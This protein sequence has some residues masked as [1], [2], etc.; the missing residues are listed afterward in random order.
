ML[1]HVRD[2]T[3][4]MWGKPRLS[5]VGCTFRSL[6]C[7]AQHSRLPGV[8]DNVAI[9]LRPAFFCWVWLL[10]DW[11]NIRS[12][13]HLRCCGTELHTI[14]RAK[15][16]N[17]LPSVGCRCQMKGA[18]SAGFC[19]RIGCQRSHIP[20]V[21][22]VVRA[23]TPHPRLSHHSPP[24]AVCLPRGEP[25]RFTLLP[26]TGRWKGADGAEKYLGARSAR[27]TSR[28][29]QEQD[30]CRGHGGRDRAAVARRPCCRCVRIVGATVDCKSLTGGSRS[31][32]ATAW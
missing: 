9:A 5:G 3:A 19:H 28:P 29:R 13:R 15:A 22:G 25:G 31:G 27:P 14:I 16:G 18:S 17:G 30:R 32:H 26:S 24:R 2:V 8:K 23:A 12:L 7:P 21:G 10:L 11:F 1:R 20:D 6:R 4:S